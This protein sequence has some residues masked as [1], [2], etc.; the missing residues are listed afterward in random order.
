[1]DNQSKIIWRRLWSYLRPDQKYLWGAI[2]C[3]IGAGAVDLKVVSLLRPFLDTTT[4]SV[5]KQSVSTADLQTL[6]WVSFSLVGLYA[7][8][9]A[10]NY[11]ETV[12]FA[13]SGQRLA[14]RLRNDIYRHLQGLSLTF[15]NQQRT[16]ALMST[17]NNDV[18]LL[19]G[20]LAGLKD[21][22]SAPFVVI[23][24][25]WLIFHISW[26]LSLAVLLVVPLMVWTIGSLTRLIRS[27][28]THTQDKLADVN[29]L[30]EET[31]SGV[32]VIQSFGAEEQEVRRF[33]S[34][35]R[36]AKD[37]S[38]AA[39]RQGAKIKPMTDLIGAVAIA[40]AL[41]IAGHEVITHAMTMGQL[42]AFIYLLNK[43][44][45]GVSSLG[46]VKVLSEQMLAGGGR[47]LRNVL[48]VHSEIQDVPGA[49]ELATVDGRVEFE[50]VAFSY[51][52]ETPVLRDVSFT[53]NPGE[54][55][56]VVG[57]SGAG[58][59]TL[60]DLI[61][62]FYDPQAGAVRVDGH[63]V[64]EVTLSSLRRHIGIVPQ[65]TILFGGT[66]RDNIAY[67]NPLATDEMVEAAARA[68]NAHGFITEPGVLPHGYQT[69][70]GERGKQLSGGQRQR[71]AIARALLKDPRILILDE[72]TSSLDAESE[73]V[74]QEALDTLMRGRTTLVIAHRLST[75]RNAHKILVM[76][77]GE[78][79]ETGS[80][81]TLMRRPDG[82]YRH[83]YERFHEKTPERKP[84]DWAEPALAAS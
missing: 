71:I 73:K 63:D 11:A 33:A 37:R 51:N 40:L 7:I 26:K 58:K 36:E 34:E 18:P 44:A 14:L 56:A 8:R 12:W 38:M 52:P 2:L 64:R 22:A 3:A 84:M 6:Y 48:D 20:I 32:R 78:I 17:I 42:A 29:T 59:S 41:W 49:A 43:I 74:V 75:I 39:I 67:G 31:L 25:V 62:R 4:D 82:L 16:G 66:I 21:V 1:M 80:H 9:A 27:L 68:A 5:H 65:E 77:A 81:D 60:A 28:T 13:E 53:M 57:L 30:M 45:T 47:I 23:G 46:N 69:L 76:Q 15:F 72:A 79:V 24:G 50:G 61:P 55:V 54:V 83:L 70:V 10:F 35:N 19:Q